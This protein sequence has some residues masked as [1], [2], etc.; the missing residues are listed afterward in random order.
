MRELPRDEIER[1]HRWLI[2]DEEK[3]DRTIYR[4]ANDILATN[5]IVPFSIWP[6]PNGDAVRVLTKEVDYNNLPYEDQNEIEKGMIF[7]DQRRF[8]TRHIHGGPML[9]E[10]REYQPCL[11]TACPLFHTKD[12]PEGNQHG[13]CSEFK[14]AFNK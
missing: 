4:Y 12:T 9:C 5:C 1:I 11:E 3:R 10:A 13:I 8:I 6:L 14:V 2:E 7:G